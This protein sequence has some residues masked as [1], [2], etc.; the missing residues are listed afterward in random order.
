MES[1]LW[2]LRAHD[3]FDLAWPILLSLAICFTFT[4]TDFIL[5]LVTWFARVTLHGADTFRRAEPGQRPSGVVIIPSLLRN[6]S[7]LN[8]ITTTIES[9]ATNEYSSELLIIAS[10]DG[11]TDQPRLYAQLLAWVARQSYPANVHVYACGTETRL[12]KMMAV[13]AGVTFLKALVACGRH[14]AIPEIYFSVDGDGT[15][16]PH[17]LERLAA[18]LSKP[19]PITRKPR[20][21]VA[22][23][24]C[25]RPDLIWSGW[26]AFFTVKGQL[27]IQVAREFLV[28]NVSR[29]NWKWT[30]HV[31]IPG[32]LYCTWSD[33][34]VQGPQYMGFMQSIRFVDWLKWWVGFAPPKCSEST[35]PPLP[36]ALTGASDDTCIAFLASIARWKD[37]RLFFDAPRTPL[38]AFGRLIVAFFFERSHDYE[39]EARVYTYSPSTLKGLWTQRVRWN[40]SRFECAGRFWRSFWFHWDIGFPVVTHLLLVLRTVVEVA[41]YYVLL[42]YVCFK[43]DSALLPYF[44]GYAGQTMAYGLYTAMALVLE[45]EYRK[46]W[47]VIFALPLAGIHLIGINFCGCIYGVTRDLLLFGNVTNFAPEWTLTKSRCQRVALLFRARRFM[48]LCVRAVLYGDVPFGTFWLGWRE[49]LWTPGGFEGWTTGKK[50]RR[51]VPRPRLAFRRRPHFAFLCRP[52]SMPAPAEGAFLSGVGSAAALV[53]MAVRHSLRPS[54][55]P[56]V[57]PSFR[58]S[59]RPSLRPS[60]RPSFR[61]S[62]P[63]SA[64]ESM[65]PRMRLL[66]TKSSLP[67]TR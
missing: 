1:L 63:D 66:D 52:I 32:A 33:L 53:P 44:I 40:A 4:Q 6:Q 14:A 49:T 39:P 11:R 28:S 36:E 62:P 67:P 23:K 21:V 8:A 35:E 38:H 47:R 51:I 15:L 27:N 3:G 5:L 50:P 12:G 37:G 58:P 43:S 2:G 64:T 48:A 20:R 16:G 60:F 18:R 65:R 9:C 26:R 30:P 61:P 57:R 42:P 10:V 34:L 54:L 13:E 29:H 45:R 22:G 17:A 25:I 31:G 41:T 19:H 24:I 56:S 7:D 59:F 46:F 55:R